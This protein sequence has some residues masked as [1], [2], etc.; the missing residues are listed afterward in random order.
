MSAPKI[1][2]LRASKAPITCLIRASEWWLSGY[3]VGL[4]PISYRTAQGNGNA[5]LLGKNHPTDGW[6][7]YTHLTTAAS[8]E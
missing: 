4:N 8:S 6:I 1:V 5:N 3:L 7:I 2:V